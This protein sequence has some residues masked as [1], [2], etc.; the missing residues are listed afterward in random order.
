VKTSNLALANLVFGSNFFDFDLYTIT[1]AGGGTIRFATADFPIFASVTQG[2]NV[3]GAA[4]YATTP[5]VDQRESKTQAHWK[6]GFDTDTWIVVLMPR[7]FDPVTGATFPDTLGNQPW[8]AGAQAGYLDAADF[9]VD[10]AYFQTMPAWGSIPVAGVTPFGVV[11]IF[12]GVVAEVDTTDSI[13]VITANDYKSLMTYTMPRHY[14]SAQCR[15]TL[16]DVGCGLNRANYAVTGSCGAQS[17]PGTIAPIIPGFPAA[18]NSGTFTLGSIV[19]TSG[20]NAGFAR[21]IM[22]YSSGLF[23]LVNPFPFT[24]ATGDQFVCYPGC[25]K[26]LTACAQFANSANYGG[27]PW[28]PAPELA[29]S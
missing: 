2:T 9:Q 23:Q 4:T 10:R 8:L 15:W 1:L 7:P 28:I 5:F 3:L 27:Q 6:I 19:M 13:C 17:T 26:T 20:Q 16:Y 18:P 11:T 22:N 14:Y 12:A 25:N 24:V 21:T 29:S